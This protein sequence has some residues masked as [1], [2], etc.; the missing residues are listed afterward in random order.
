MS[1]AL[2]LFT[3]TFNRSVNM[4]TLAQHWH[5]G[6]PDDKGFP[7]NKPVYEDMG[8][9]G[10]VFAVA[11]M[12][13][14]FTRRFTEVLLP[15]LRAKGASSDLVTLLQDAGLDTRAALDLIQMERPLRRIRAL[16]DGHLERYTTQRFAAIDSLFLGFGLKDLCANAQKRSTR[17]TLLRSVELLVERRHSIVHAADHN[18]HGNVVILDFVE[19]TK[20]IQCLSLFITHADSIITAFESKLKPK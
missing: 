6:H 8:R 15:Y 9:S 2:K 20:R 14:Y 17:K 3:E 11:A 18:K 4:F 12:D 19:F 1:K 16:V 7:Q 10:I 5:K 13:A